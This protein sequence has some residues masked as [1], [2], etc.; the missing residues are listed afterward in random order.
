MEILEIEEKKYY[1]I[2]VKKD[3]EIIIYRRKIDGNKDTWEYSTSITTWVRTYN[4]V[5]LEKIFNEYLKNKL[6]I[7]KVSENSDF[8]KFTQIVFEK[9][10]L[11]DWKVVWGSPPSECIEEIKTIRI[12]DNLKNDLICYQCELFLHEVAHIGITTNKHN[13]EFYNNLS[14]LFKK[15]GKYIN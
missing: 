3:N 14:K 7:N 10:N 2:K 6:K 4:N 1:I 5:K 11:K 12:S 15:Y 9:E 8:Y 13:T